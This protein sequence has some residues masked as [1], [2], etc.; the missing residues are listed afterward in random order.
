MDEQHPHPSAL[1]LEALAAGD[2]DPDAQHH[3]DG[4]D[5]CQRHVEALKQTIAAFEVSPGASPA[6]LLEANASASIEGDARLPS[7]PSL[8]RDEAAGSNVLGSAPTLRPANDAV[9]PRGSWLRRV[10]I[11]GGPLV[12][13]AVVLLV[14]R[15]G[16]PVGDGASGANVGAA[17]AVATAVV[18]F[19]GSIEVA[20]IRDR[21]GAQER[22]VGP[23]S[24]RAGDRL[25]VEV[26]LP[27][28]GPL[29]AGV[30][31]DQGQWV[32]LIAPSEM[33]AGTHFSE[34]AVRFDATPTR[35]RLLVGSPEDVSRARSGQPAEGVTEIPIR[36]DATP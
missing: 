12:A 4:C 5:E 17:G 30:L 14:L 25:R 15:P 21:D 24:V 16:A 3:V 18:R 11:V 31:D 2:P 33:S 8:T 34:R 1:R 22:L 7:E 23:V 27:A 35:G 32:P 13:A 20:V 19:K 28:P 9:A 6:W 29:S 10:A 26:A 36:Y